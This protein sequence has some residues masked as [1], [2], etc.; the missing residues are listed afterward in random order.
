M[1]A[2]SLRVGS[3]TFAPGLV[4]TFVL[5]PL[6]AL[7]LALGFWQLR[8]ADEKRVLYEGFARGTDRTLALPPASTPAPRYAHVRVSGS[9]LPER[10]FL[11]DNMTHDERAGYRVLTPLERTDG[12]TVLVDRGWVP[13]GATRAEL[14]PVA[15]AGT[16]REVMGRVDLLPRAGI[17]LASTPGSG[18]P[19]VASFPTLPQLESALGRPLYPQ[20]VLL[21]PTLPDGYVRDWSPPGFPPIRHIG[22]AVQWFGLALTLVIIYVVVNLKKNA[23]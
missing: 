13:A 22:Y 16:P 9:Y 20:I 12:E 21:D 17:T 15:V 4:P 3:R 5:I 10:Q 14:P 6:L 8:R 2:F 19:R 7:L 11:L 23:P 18:W 1:P